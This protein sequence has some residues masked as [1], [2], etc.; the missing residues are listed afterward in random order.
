MMVLRTATINNPNPKKSDRKLS[1]FAFRCSTTTYASFVM[2][3]KS[4]PDTPNWREF[5]E[6]AE[7]ISDINLV[8]E[9]WRELSSIDENDLLFT[10][11]TRYTEE[12]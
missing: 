2:H 1:F 9:K 8:S 5:P 3:L 11:L 10:E 6:K 7:I 4:P 12:T